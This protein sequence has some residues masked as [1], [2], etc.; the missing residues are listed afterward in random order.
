VSRTPASLERID[1]FSALYPARLHELCAP[2]EALYVAG[3][4]DRLAILSDSEPVAIVGTRRPSEYGKGITR[5]LASGLACA[6]VPVVSGMALGIDTVAHEAAI[7][8]RGVTVAVL[9]GGAER[10]HP[11]S[12]ARLYERILEDG[13][14]ISEQPPGRTPRRW[15][16]AARNRIIAAL[17]SATVVVEAGEESGALLTSTAAAEL[18]RP[19]G[20]V[21]GRVGS[22]HAAGPNAL[23]ADGAAV[24]R[25]PDD[26]LDLVYGAGAWSAPAREREP[27]D[28][29]LEQ[30]LEAIQEGHESTAALARAGI[31]PEQG[32]AALAQLELS[33]H[34]TRGPGGRYT[35]GT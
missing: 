26:A 10:A 35:V 13:L 23:L 19:V 32:L 17:A 30:L 29:A 33:G 2:P 24:I 1:R 9:A 25:G 11:P 12:R 28:P 20:A 7:A 34:V 21:P 16:F 31:A 15:S 18:G 22:R 4:V 27:L 3:C 5:T 14:V 8:Y 6:G